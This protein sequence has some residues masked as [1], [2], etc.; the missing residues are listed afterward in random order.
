METNTGS[1]FWFV[2]FA[3]IGGVFVLV[4]ILMEVLSEKNWFKSIKHFRRCETT[5]KFGEWILIFGIVIEVVVAGFSAVDEWQ[6]IQTVSKNNPLK[7]PVSQV[8]A[9]LR[10]VVDAKDYDPR[11]QISLENT[12][13]TT[14]AFTLWAKEA[15]WFEHV[16][17]F[18]THHV[19]FYGIAVRFEQNILPSGEWNDINST[20]ADLML[21]TIAVTNAISGASTLFAYVDFIPKN[22]TLIK[23]SARVFFNGFRKDFQISSNSLNKDFSEWNPERPG[24]FLTVTNSSP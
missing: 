14:G 13:M 11:K 9:I 24:I 23:G 12:H 1:V 17:N 5:K 4:G 6:T 10:I 3:T 21:A 16:D 19:A 8:S 20:N 15:R 18:A 7:Q 22:S 2:L